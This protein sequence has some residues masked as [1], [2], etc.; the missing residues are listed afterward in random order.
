MIREGKLKTGERLPP[1]RT[2][3]EMFNVSRASV[4][5]A[6][7]AMEIIGLIEVRQ[8]EGSYITDLNIAPFIN[9]IAPLFIKNDN[10]ETDLLDFRKLL[11]IEAVSLAADKN[12]GSDILMLEKCL[13]EM[14]D[15]IIRNDMNLGAEADIKFHK[16]IFAVTNNV[17]LIKAAEFT[18]YILE[19][20]IKFNR[21]KILNNGDNSKVLYSQHG[22]IYDALKKRNRKLAGELMEHHL[23]FV[24]EMNANKY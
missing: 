24:K 9:T 22:Q 2:L 18:A 19:R 23:N 17:V 12:D 6:F 8:G 1:E 20:S 14:R 3:A 4:R 7:S 10:L 21:S 11:E 15:A 16:T 13:D 5:E